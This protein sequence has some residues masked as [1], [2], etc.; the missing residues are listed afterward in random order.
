MK[1]DDGSGHYA[2]NG[3]PP[4]KKFSSKSKDAGLYDTTLLYADSKHKGL[5]LGGNSTVTTF[6]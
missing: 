2:T 3:F 1:F 5:T 4:R 6:G